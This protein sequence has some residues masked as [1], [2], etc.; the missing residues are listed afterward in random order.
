MDQGV[1][2]LGKPSMFKMLSPSITYMYTYI[3]IYILSCS[4][5]LGA[6]AQPCKNAWMVQVAASSQQLEPDD[7]PA[8]DSKPQRYWFLGLY[9]S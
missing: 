8:R 4:L 3:Y 2:V 9:F 5:I 6:K 7:V 1:L